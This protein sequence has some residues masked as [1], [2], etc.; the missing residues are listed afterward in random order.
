[1]QPKFQ[2]TS[3]KKKKVKIFAITIKMIKEDELLNIKTCV[4]AFWCY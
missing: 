2:Q 3:A 4:Y 1:M